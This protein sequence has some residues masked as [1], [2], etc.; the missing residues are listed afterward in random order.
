MAKPEM[1]ESKSESIK[2]SWRLLAPFS[3]SM[4]KGTQEPGEEWYE[5][6]IEQGKQE[7]VA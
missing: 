2:R 5:V 6:G 4:A 1:A 3:G 7:S